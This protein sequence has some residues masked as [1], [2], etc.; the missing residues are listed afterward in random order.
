MGLQATEK[1]SGGDAPGVMN[2]LQ[3]LAL[4]RSMAGMPDANR[5]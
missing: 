2:R 5:A 4:R 1:T 3:P